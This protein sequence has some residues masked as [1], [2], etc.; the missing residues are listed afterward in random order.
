MSS[1]RAKI[2]PNFLKNESSQS[3][4]ILPLTEKTDTNNMFTFQFFNYKIDLNT[5][6]AKLPSAKWPFSNFSCM[7]LNPNIFFQFES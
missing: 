6:F 4:Q 1:S 7:F 2:G 5:N 3:S